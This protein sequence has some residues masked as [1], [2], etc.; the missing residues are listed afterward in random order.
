MKPYDS[1]CSFYR[2]KEQTKGEY[3]SIGSNGNVLRWRD[4]K[5]TEQVWL[6]V[7]VGENQVQ[8]MTR[9]EGHLGEYL[10]VGSDGNI[11]RWS[12]SGKDDQIFE[13]V[14]P[15][16]DGCWEIKEGTKGERVAVGSNGNIL[17]WK[18]SR[19]KDQ[20]F[21][22][23]PWKAAAKPRLQAGECGPGEIGDPP[24]IL[25][26]EG[27]L[28]ERSEVHLIAETLLPA[29]VVHDDEFGDLIVQVEQ[30]PYYILR[31]EQFWDRSGERGFSRY[32]AGKTEEVFQRTL[33]YL[34]T[35]TSGRSSETAVRLEFGVNGGY[36]RKS[37]GGPSISLALSRKVSN[38]LKTTE[39]QTEQIE[40]E[41]EYV[42]RQTFPVGDP[43]RL[44]AW[45]LVDRYT[46]MRT[47]RTP[48][49]V[50]EV[51]LD[52]TSVVDGFPRPET[53]ALQASLKR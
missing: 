41:Q 38:E 16:R 31:R 9:Q 10:A 40:K 46:L 14:N 32:H 7:P 21:K 53:T 39:H 29:T 45:T 42:Y 6:P 15:T 36:S 27:P 11:L 48:V 26:F 49:A 30:T 43:F 4:T 3:V 52:N 33:R 17:R 12:E 5:G 20:K 13:L 24:R 18:P 35:N 28:P 2:L 37:G 1:S 47:S 23:E 34:V 19:G 51:A 22:L 25:S 50:W 8:F 44:V